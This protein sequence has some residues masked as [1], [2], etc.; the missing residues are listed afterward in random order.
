MLPYFQFDRPGAPLLPFQL[1]SPHYQPYL[2]CGK[3]ELVRSLNV[4]GCDKCKLGGQDALTPCGILL[5]IFEEEQ[6][7]KITCN[8]F[9]T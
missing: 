2:S 6:Q 9:V 7:V 4:Q 3:I 1:L 8:V 5:T